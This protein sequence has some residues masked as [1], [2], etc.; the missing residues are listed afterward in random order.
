MGKTSKKKTGGTTFEAASGLVDVGSDLSAFGCVH[1]TANSAKFGGMQMSCNSTDGTATDMTATTPG[2]AGK[3]IKFG[4]IHYNTAKLYCCKSSDSAACDP[5]AS[6][7]KSPA[8][9]PTATIAIL[10]ALIAAML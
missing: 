8:N 5:K 2:G 10:A 1:A 6:A 4:T 9:M 3:E 7:S